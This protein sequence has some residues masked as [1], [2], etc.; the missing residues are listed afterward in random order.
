[1]ADRIFVDV[2]SAF[3]VVRGFWRHRAMLLHR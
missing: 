3:L 2:V 1:M